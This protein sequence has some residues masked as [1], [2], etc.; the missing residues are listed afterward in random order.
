MFKVNNKDTRATPLTLNMQ[1]PAG[2]LENTTFEC[3]LSIFDEPP[4]CVDFQ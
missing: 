3:E 2:L 1:L 4:Y